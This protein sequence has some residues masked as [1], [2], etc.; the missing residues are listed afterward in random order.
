MRTRVIIIVA[1]L[2]IALFGAHSAVAYGTY[3]SQ[4]FAAAVC[5]ETPITGQWTVSSNVYMNRADGFPAGVVGTGGTTGPY[6]TG[7]GSWTVIDGNS[8]QWLYYRV[9]VGTQTSSG[10]SWTPGTWMRRQDQLGDGTDGLSTEVE[11]YPGS[12]VYVRTGYAATSSPEDVSLVSGQIGVGPRSKY[13]YGQM[14]WGPIYNLKN[15]Q[16]FAPYTH[17][18][19]IGWV[20]CG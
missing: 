16:V 4:H 14:W 6:F 17:W 1:I 20:N 5:R 10:W 12:G 11:T 8:Q 18:E 2:A 15:Q 7:G 19:P 9:V 3:P 13:I